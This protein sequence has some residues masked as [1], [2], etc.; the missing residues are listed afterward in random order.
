MK[1]VFYIDGRARD[2]LFFAPSEIKQISIS[3]SNKGIDEDPD[4]VFDIDSAWAGIEG[5]GVFTKKIQD[6]NNWISE[7]DHTKR[8]PPTY[9]NTCTFQINLNDFE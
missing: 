4:C 8:I 1:L 2:T 9:E 6:Q 5:K 7:S 3:T